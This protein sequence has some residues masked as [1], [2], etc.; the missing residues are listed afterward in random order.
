VSTAV[1]DRPVSASPLSGGAPARRAVIRWAWRLFR[2]EWRQQLTV[3]GLLVV[4]VAAAVGAIAFAS[5]GSSSP[6]ADFGTAN[7]MLIISGSEPQQAADVALAASRFSQI[8]VIKHAKAAIPGSVNTVD[9][10]SQ[11]PDG[12]YSSPMLRLDAGHY[13]AAGQVAVTSGVAAIYRL[14]IGS[15]W[16]EGGRAL[17]VVG[18][19]ENPGNLQDQFALVAP[20]QLGNADQVTVLFDATDR[21]VRAAGLPPGAQLQ[22]RPAYNPGF[23]PAAVLVFDTIAL[24][25]IGLIAVAGFTVLAQ[26]RL[27]ALGMLQAVGATDRHVR[28]VLIANGAVVG[29]IA[30][31]IGAAAALAGW[32]AFVPRL[33][34]IVQHR[35]TTFSLPWWE[36]AAAIVLAVVTAVAASW[37]PARAAARVPVVAALSGRPAS[38]KQGRRPAALG[39]A[40]LVVGLAGI[41]VSHQGKTAPLLIAGLIL[42]AVG[43]L[44]LGPLAIGAL[45]VVGTHAPL[46]IR[47]ALRDLARYRARSGAA[48]AA[49]SLV[50]GIVA[51]IAISAAAAA[52]NEATAGEAGWANLPASQLIVY[53]SPGG[54]GQMP[55]VTP[56]LSGAQLVRDHA[57]ASH[58]AAAVHAQHVLPLYAAVAGGAQPFPQGPA[59]DAAELTGY[60]TANLASPVNGPNGHQGLE[61]FGQ[62]YVATRAVLSFYGLRASAV[63]ATTEIITSRSSLTGTKILDFGS[64]TVRCRTGH[65]TCLYQG[66][67]VRSGTRIPFSLR[68]GIS[69]TFQ[70][71]GL[72]RYTSAP[73]T[74][75][76][77]HGMTVLGLHPVLAGWL[78]QTPKALTPAQVAQA[79]HWAAANGLT[80]ETTSH[81][82]QAG[83][84]SVSDWA[85]AIGVLA[86]LAVLA[87]TV[88]L[89]RSETGGDLRVLSATG[90]SGGTRRLLTGATAGALALLGAVLGT[91][92][93]YLGIIAWNRGLHSLTAVPAAKLA[94][95]IVGL[96]LLAL[97]AA[98]LL[99]GREPPAIAQ[100]PLE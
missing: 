32:A 24:L 27:R 16:H 4:A 18:I 83:L 69:P 40:L 29:I 79:D 13:P 51:A 89:I 19:V 30:A 52:Q 66:Q 25:F 21:Q 94:M 86:V 57:N 35:I 55:E 23:P 53:V 58:I 5:N 82:A 75:L 15:V 34:T 61:I 90:A 38:P 78:I 50:T 68:G 96:P 45:A 67:K 39:G 77:A 46:A 91:A 93:A 41:A 59:T 12:P 43:V 65:V 98:W 8:E 3:I 37:W 11:Q 7:H 9:L 26:R 88:G 84:Q 62:L 10:R 47:L 60:L 36:V 92:A 85:I 64:L 72:P 100:Q 48:L 95:L 6:S 54:A 31:A 99:A 49:I 71:L 87:M 97:A 81:S 17:P 28:L 73:S 22:T 33:E 2:R 74:L 44:L 1:Q 14:R 70:V 56:P 80:V 42:T 76:T 63:R 20:G